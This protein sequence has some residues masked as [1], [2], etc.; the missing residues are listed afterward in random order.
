MLT[1]L[2]EL[3]LLEALKGH[4]DD[5]IEYHVSYARILQNHFG[6]RCNGRG[7][8]RWR[9]GK[10]LRIFHVAC[11]TLCRDLRHLEEAG[12]IERIQGFNG[13]GVNLTPEGVEFTRE[14]KEQTV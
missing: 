12:L 8:I 11:S 4:D 7:N 1:E 9:S 5:L 6:I 2:Q 10:E 14:L 13:R 3:V